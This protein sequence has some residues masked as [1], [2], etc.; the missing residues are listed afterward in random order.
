MTTK[1]AKPQQTP[2][3]RY[4]AAR[5]NL[6]L[7]VIFTAINVVMLMLGTNTQFLFSAAFPSVAY[8]VGDFL[9]VETGIE[10]FRVGALMLALGNIGLYLL[11]WF[12]SKRHRGFMV[13]ALILFILDCLAFLSKFVL[14]EIDAS[15]AMDVMFHIWVLWALISGVVAMAALKKQERQAALD[16]AQAAQPAPEDPYHTQPEPQAAAAEGEQR[17]T[18]QS[19]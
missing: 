14:Y 11:C 7:V 8:A 3:Q 2:E 10:L 18:D 5:G 1:K 12:C 9:T 17:G 6:M 4:N 13:F 16:P 19:V 15:I